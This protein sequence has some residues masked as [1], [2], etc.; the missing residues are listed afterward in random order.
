MVALGP[1]VF[2]PLASAVTETAARHALVPQ[3]HDLVVDRTQAVLLA[4][5]L[6]DDIR[7]SGTTL[8]LVGF[9]ASLDP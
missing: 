5:D 2:P 4:R 3:M 9:I 8:A 7:A 6:I 1:Q